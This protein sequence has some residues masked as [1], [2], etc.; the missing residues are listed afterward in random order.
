MP[1]AR[2]TEV[3]STRPRCWGSALRSPAAHM[4]AQLHQYQAELAFGELL[5]LGLCLLF[6]TNTMCV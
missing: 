2:G 1:K 6:Y 3:G 4:H 5:S